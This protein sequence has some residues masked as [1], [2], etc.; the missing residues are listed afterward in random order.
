MLSCVLF[1]YVGAKH[2]YAQWFINISN[3]TPQIAYNGMSQTYYLY[4]AH[5]LLTCLETRQALS[6]I[7]L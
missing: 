2:R 6:Y 3:K 4:T 7:M 1:D 5:T